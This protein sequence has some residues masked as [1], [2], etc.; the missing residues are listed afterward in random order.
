[1]ADTVPGMHKGLGWLSAPHTTKVSFF[2]NK[3]TKLAPRSER[4]S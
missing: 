4:S 3:K 1:M 2:L